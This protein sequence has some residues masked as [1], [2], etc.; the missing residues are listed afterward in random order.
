MTPVRAIVSGLAV[1]EKEIAAAPV[2]EA[3]EVNVIQLALLDAVHG[4]DAPEALKEKLPVAAGAPNDAPPD[5]NENTQLAGACT[6]VCDWSPTV[7][8]EVR[9]AA[10]GLAATR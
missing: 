9:D 6:T 3:G 10:P 4:Q 5:G 8:W 1:R 2:P 7:M